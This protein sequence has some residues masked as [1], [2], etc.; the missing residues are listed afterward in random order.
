MTASAGSSTSRCRRTTRRSARR[1]TVRATWSAAALGVPPGRMNARSGS[2]SAS[3]VVDRLLELRDA[4][5]VDA[6]LL[7]MLR[8][9]LAVGGGEQRADGEQ[10]ALHGDE[11]LV[12]ARH[13]LDG[14]RHPDD[15]VQLV[16][17]TICLDARIVLGNAPAAEEPRVAAVAGLACRSSREK[18]SA[19]ADPRRTRSSNCT[20]P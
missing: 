1:H 9:L 10:V 3:R 4:A 16:D 5:L 7:E 2:S 12:D 20:L 15:G 18:Y 11:H 6:R 17:V 19:R 13:H 8:H 14:A